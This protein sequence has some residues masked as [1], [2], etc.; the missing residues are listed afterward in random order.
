MRF[1][2]LGMFLLNLALTCQAQQAEATIYGRISDQE[3]QTI[4]YPVNVAVLGSNSGTISHQDGEYT[5]KVPALQTIVV[6][7]SCTGYE[8]SQDTLNL[9]ANTRFKL[10]KQLLKGLTMD[11]VVVRHER[12]RGTSFKPIETQLA[13]IAPDI[14]GGD[15]SSMV[16]TN[17]GVAS[18]NEL[19]SQYSVRGGNFDENLVY[20]NGI[21]VYRP[22]LVRAG[23]QEG[24]SFTNIDMVEE[25]RFSAGGFDAKYGDKMSSVL[26]ITYKKPQKFAASLSGSLL[27]GAAHI[28]GCSNDKRF[29][30]I[31][32]IRYKSSRYVLNSLETKGDYK[33]SFLD[34][35]S[36]LTYEI[37]RFEI[38]VLGNV[39]RNV[40]LYDPKDRD[41]DFG[42]IQN[43]LNIYIDFEGRELDHFSTYTGALSLRYKSPD[44]R[45][46]LRL[47]ASSFYTD[48]EENYDIEGRYSLNM[49][50]QSL[51]SESFGDSSLNL[52]I[53]SYLDHARNE[54]NITVANIAHTGLY[55]WGKHG[56]HHL[57]WG[58]KFQQEII[59]DYINE[60]KILDSAGYALPHPNVVPY[61]K[62][63]LD[64]FW[65]TN[66]TIDMTSNRLTAHIQDHVVLEGDKAKWMLTGGLRANYWDF[67]EEL[68][69]SPRASIS[70]DPI[71]QRDFMF[72]LASGVYYQ[73]PF[74]RELRNFDGEIAADASAQRSIHVVLESDYNFWAWDRRFKFVSALYYKDLYNLIPYE[75]DNV[76]IRYYANQ[77]ADGYAL[78]LDMKI[79]GEFV[80]GVESWANL[81]FM[82]T[83]ENIRQ[84]GYGY[85]DRPND[86]L[87]NFSLF[88]Q[89]YFPGNETYK[90]SLTMLF[91]SRLPIGPPREGR[92]KATLTLPT[93]KRVDIGLS[94]AIIPKDEDRRGLK[95]LWLSAEV[96]NLLDV[97]NTISYL[98]V[99]VVP[100]TAVA[101]LEETAMYAIPNRLTARR[102]NLRLIANF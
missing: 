41:T 77:R 3:G 70:I 19:S 53:G 93:Y 43:S 63:Q 62:Q 24:L 79:H 50:D 54:L 78:G 69:F 30:H 42:S 38:A 64:L 71:W 29:R 48:E 45:L 21:E 94:K 33:P 55:K 46:M 28:Q 49:L 82:H 32:G 97:R 61:P 12:D 13:K 37:G 92:E 36:Y 7:F 84:D 74:Y 17:L 99:S 1:I 91:G 5:L 101:G 2:L 11:S 88:F 90:M 57:D 98:W 20:V 25:A 67:S 86:Q 89:D 87:V 9:P 26:D 60:W 52:G 16:K 44:D 73:P 56:R 80:K 81:S 4:K 34:F 102:F 51:D 100:N 85:I 14:M 83:Q 96:F 15:I 95:S 47:V 27:G 58:V 8:S 68:L 65:V 22:M 39:A 6:V 66:S 75:Y 76:R 23:E 59:N 40:F 31:S 35:Q 18:G 10:N 72:R